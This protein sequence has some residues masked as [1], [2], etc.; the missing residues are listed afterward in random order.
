MT[1]LPIVVVVAFI[2]LVGGMVGYNAWATDRERPTPLVV[3]VTARQRTLVERYVK[4][5]VLKLDGV[6]ADPASSAQILRTTADAL[7]DGGK[8]VSPQGSLDQFVTIPAATDGAVRLKLE[9]ERKLIDELLT[10][11]LGAARR[12]SDQPDLR[13]TDLRQFRV[14]GAELSSVTGDATGEITKVSQTSLS[15]QRR[16][17]ARHRVGVPRLA[18]GWLLRRTAERQ[19]ARFRSLVHNSTDLIT[20]LDEH[21]V[22]RYQSPSSIRVLGYQPDEIVGTKLTELLHPDDK[23]TVIETFA[24][25]AEKPA[26]S[27]WSCTAG[28][29]TATAST[30]SWRAR[31]RCSLN[32]LRRQPRP[33]RPFGTH[34]GRPP[35]GLRSPRRPPLACY[36]RCY[37]HHR[38]RPNEQP[39]DA[40]RS[41]H[42]RRP[43]QRHLPGRSDAGT[44]NVI[45]L[46]GVSGTITLRPC[47]RRSSPPAAAACSSTGPVRPT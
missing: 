20:V 17:P 35:S 19:S 10:R 8:V 33:R 5:V 16:D 37:A 24:R 2:V 25:V 32:W 14:V 11:W 31:R 23:R 22:A 26:A 45:D 43:A 1:A 6:A 36:I 15:C 30:A 21:A 12:R 3:D 7:L 9:H 40:A 38:H 41:R 46:T 4:D 39:G 34:L 18:M 27:P 28:S 42:A 13:V 44:A 47:C 29:G